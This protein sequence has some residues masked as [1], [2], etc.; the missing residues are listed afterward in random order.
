MAPFKPVKLLDLCKVAPPR[1]SVVPTYTSLPLTFFDLLWLPLPP[2]EL[3]F[4]YDFPY[5]I[6]QFTH[7]LLPHLKQSLSCTLIHFYPFS[8]NLSWPHDPN[9]PMI[10]YTEGDSVSFSVA[11]SD[12]DFYHLSSNNLKDAI[13]SRPLVPHLPAS[14][15]IVPMLALQVTVF[16]NNGICI[17][18]THHH[19]V[20]DGRGFTHFM[21][22][23][24]SISK[25]GVESLSPESLPFLDRTTIKEDYGITKI[26]LNDL[27]RFMGSETIL[28][29]RRLR[30]MDIEL[31]P[32]MVRAT[33]EV[34]EASGRRLKE[35]IF[36]QYK[37]DEQQ[38]IPPSKF[39]AICAY[40]WICL[41]KA[42]AKVGESKTNNTTS[43][44]FNVDCRARLD[45][46]IQE[47]YLGN[48]IRSGVV[49]AEKTDLM[50]EVA[51]AAQL[52]RNVVLEMDKGILRGMERS[53]SDLLEMQY[54][55]ILAAAGSSQLGL[56]KI[57]FGFGKPK[58]VEMASIDRTGAMFLKESSNEGGGIEFDLVLNR[59][60]MDAFVSVFVG[61]LNV[62]S[63]HSLS[64]ST[65]RSLL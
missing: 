33:F 49:I 54:S 29:N 59:K 3:L 8:G 39:A 56:Y 51:V 44:V 32:N 62:L 17:A 23:W 46:P 61:G 15:P 14:G 35:W 63:E 26:L 41:L 34:N 31:K 18:A 28:G 11:E 50:R 22:T 27:D 64:P 21:R 37:K 42:E 58:K 47:T 60:E 20:C 55:R 12:A 65:S 6:S 24:A 52:I 4:F 57:D 36:S 16:P 45:P 13:E 40:T 38:T 25:L 5:P 53:V 43:F 9:H 7:S 10:C 19:S 30:V 1:G 2:V 48:C